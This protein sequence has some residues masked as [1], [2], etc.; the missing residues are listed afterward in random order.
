MPERGSEFMERVLGEVWKPVDGW[1]YEVSSHGRVRRTEAGGNRAKVG[2]CLQ[3]IAKSNGYCAVSLNRAERDEDVGDRRHWKAERK[4]MSV[5]RLVYEAFFGAIPAGLQVNHRD[6]D[7]QNNRLSNLEITTAQGNMRH[8]YR[9]GLRDAKGS[10]N[11][12]SKLDEDKVKEIRLLAENGADWHS[13]ADRFGVS[14][15]AV[16][17]VVKRTRW[18]HVE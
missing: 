5:H 11:G 12:R 15:H 16:K 10:Q 7:K 3:P 1:P 9:L 4:Q 14:Y 13:I 6:G 18:A 17:H 8:A 2:E